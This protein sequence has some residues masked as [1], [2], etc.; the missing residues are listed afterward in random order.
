MEILIREGK[1]EDLENMNEL[2]EELDEYHRIN[3]PNIFKK[4]DIIGRPLEHIKN[5]C[6]NSDSEIFVAELDGKLIGMAEIL[7][8]RT[9]PYPLKKDREWVVLDT[10]VV[11]K[12]YR[13]KGI[14]NI[15]FDSILD[16]T[17]DKKINRIEVNVYEF[18]NSAIK[19]YEN[20]GFRNFNRIMYLEV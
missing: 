13:G 11:K 18:N 10:I 15:L 8:K 7:K 9:V 12:E 2:F 4:G 5:M 14:G 1:I 17:K 19:F 6:E 16:W 20:L 3:L